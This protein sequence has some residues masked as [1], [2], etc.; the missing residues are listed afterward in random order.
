MENLLPGDVVLCFRVDVKM[1]AK[2]NASI[3]VICDCNLEITS[4]N[5][6]ENE[7]GTWIY[8]G[9]KTSEG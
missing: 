5:Y 6:C 9:H 3:L 1:Y 8:L 2:R 7:E 4:D